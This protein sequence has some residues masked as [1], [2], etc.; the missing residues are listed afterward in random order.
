MNSPIKV[1]LD[2]NIFINARF[3]REGVKYRIINDCIDGVLQALYTDKL[4]AEAERMLDKFGASAI[5]K[6]RVKAY[7]YAA[8]YVENPVDLKVCEDPADD[9]FLEC[10]VS[11]EANYIISDA[12]HLK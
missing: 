6:N 8:T 1:V 2:T 4:K 12:D 10:A 7:F 9:M 5:Y 3:K 11:G